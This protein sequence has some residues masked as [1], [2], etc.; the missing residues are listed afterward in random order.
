[1]VAL[2]NAETDDGLLCASHGDEHVLVTLGEQLVTLHARLLL[3]NEAP[4]LV[5]QADLA[6]RF[7]VAVID[8]K[9]GAASEGHDGPIFREGLASH[10]DQL[11][12]C[13]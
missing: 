8:A 7:H 2:A 11:A 13:I 5:Q 9:L 10:V 3:T 4:Q 12:A 1:M 6:V